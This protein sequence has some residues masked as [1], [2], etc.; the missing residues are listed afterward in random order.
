M[1]YLF[2]LFAYLLGSIPSGYILFRLKE[3]KD[4]RTLGSTNIGATNILRVTGWKMALPVAIIDV[5]KGVLPVFL[6]GKL[7]SDHRIAII[8]GF[9]AVL[10]HCFPVY[11]RFKGGKGAATT[12][13]VYSILAPIPLLCVMAVFIIVIALTRFV[14]LGSLLAAF[15]FPLFAFAFKINTAIVYL[16]ICIF[17]MII[18]RHR[19][20]I[21][22]LLG[23]TERRLGDKA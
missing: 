2:F 3:K 17:I 7:F 4:I 1:K 13:G 16:G 14:S 10:G 19:E 21:E 5:L 22:R 20:N 18:Y 9:F 12:V 11:I 23:G 15:S 6:A 8:S